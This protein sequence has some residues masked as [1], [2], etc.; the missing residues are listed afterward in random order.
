MMRMLRR[1]LILRM[2]RF[3]M[4]WRGSAGPP[5]ST[6]RHLLAHASGLAMLNGQTL[7][8]MDDEGH[9]VV[10]DSFLLL[11]NAADGGVEFTLPASPSG[12]AWCQIVDTENIDNPFAETEPCEKV[13]VGGRA[14][15]LMSDHSSG[16]EEGRPPSVS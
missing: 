10:D 14:L 15:K 5:G 13:F 2:T 9:P 12:N 16:G 1:R 3:R 11:V 7:Q 8:V 4:W 6:V